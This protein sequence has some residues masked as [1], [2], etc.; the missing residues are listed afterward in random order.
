MQR[1]D[2]MRCDAMRCDATTTHTFPMRNLRACM[3]YM[4]VHL[5]GTPARITSCD[6]TTTTTT[7]TTATEP[8][9]RVPGDAL[10]ASLLLPRDQGG[11]EKAQRQG[12]QSRSRDKFI[13]WDVAQCRRARCA[14]GINVLPETGT[15]LLLGPLSDFCVATLVRSCTRVCHLS[16]R[17]LFVDNVCN[18]VIR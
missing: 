10:P 2:A 4:S 7:T 18:I 6:L 15:A 16:M 5:C 1:C 9:A 17:R 8:S 12:Y 3:R 14:V 13:C 11:R